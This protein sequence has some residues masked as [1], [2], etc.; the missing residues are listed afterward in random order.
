MWILRLFSDPEACPGKFCPSNLNEVHT[1]SFHLTAGWVFTIMDQGTLLALQILCVLGKWSDKQVIVERKIL[2]IIGTTLSPIPWCGI[3]VNITLWLRIPHWYL[4]ADLFTSPCGTDLSFL[5]G[6]VIICPWLGFQF[7]DSPL[8]PE[9]H[10]DLYN[11]S[12]MPL[13]LSKTFDGFLLQL[14]IYFLFFK[15]IKKFIWGNSLLKPKKSGID[16]DCFQ[17]F[18]RVHSQGAIRSKGTGLLK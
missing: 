10:R 8:R 7:R 16:W 11:H 4:L 14:F 15:A 12:I 9:F 1:I 3:L 13:S 6:T 5:P 17:K 18:W 2:E